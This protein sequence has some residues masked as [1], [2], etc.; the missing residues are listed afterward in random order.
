MVNFHESAIDGR[1]FPEGGECDRMDS[2]L[3]V[4]RHIVLHVPDPILHVDTT[5]RV[6]VANR[7][8]LEA[9]RRQR[10]EVIGRSLEETAEPGLWA[11]IRQP[12]QEALAGQAAEFRIRARFAPSA[13]PLLLDVILV[14]RRNDA[15]AVVGATVVFHDISGPD[16]AK[17]QQRLE[18][19]RLQAILR[20]IPEGVYI[21]NRHYE[22]EYANPVLLREFGPVDDRKCYQYLQQRTSPCPD[23]RNDEIF[24]GKTI[25]RRVYCATCDKEFEIHNAPLQTTGEPPAKMVFLRDI[26]ERVRMEEDLR[27]ANDLLNSII[28]NT[29]AVIYVKDLSGRYLLANRQFNTLFSRPG[30]EVTG[31]TDFEIFPLESARRFRE[32]DQQVLA[33]QQTLQFEEQV[34]HNGRQHTFLSIKFPLFASDGTPYAVAGI[35][36]DISQR[37]HAEKALQE[38][39]EQL[40]VLINASPDIICFKDSRGRWLLA[41]QAI[42]ELF[43]INGI[44]Y[45]GRTDAE[46]GE[47]SHFYRQALEHCSRTDELCWQ[48]R[49]VARHDEIIL[50][51]DGTTKVYDVLKIPLFHT[52]GR[53]KG[54]VVLGRDVSERVKAE[55]A[56][57]AEKERSDKT[58]IT[59]KVLL[60][61]YQYIGKKAEKQ[62]SDQLKTLIFPY[63]DHLIAIT[64]DERVRELLNIISSNIQALAESCAEK[65][66]VMDRRLQQLTPR[67]TLIVNLIQQGKSSRDIARILNLSKRTVDVYRQNIRK[68]LELTNNRIQ[69]AEYL[70]LL[71][72]GQ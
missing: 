63:L 50:R 7:A 10:A 71:G 60:E 21:A 65:R 46:L 64:E 67:E 33:A 17:E 16:Q 49:K 24:A 22:I 2:I 3:S 5:C 44:D 8:Y 54:L 35:S 53:R 36:T 30:S 41:N 29:S 20:A 38:K 39:N 48:S 51:A 26:T 69:L 1:P 28:N 6:M 62:V 56:L 58:N 12:L 47:C 32:N 70:R 23:C 57:R 11:A 31:S 52:D 40:H 13:R 59:L 19:E 27:K 43:E 68:K 25:C 72:P 37:I 18:Q 9:C 61:Q 45:R 55:E 14:P 34:L 4:Y 42:L 66:S 15:G